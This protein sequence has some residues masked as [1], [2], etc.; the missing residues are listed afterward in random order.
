[1][2]G[3][4]RLIIAGIIGLILAVLIFLGFFIVKEKEENKKEGID[5]SKQ[6]KAAVVKAQEEVTKLVKSYVDGN[7]E[8]IKEYAEENSKVEFTIKELKGIFEIDTKKFNELK[9]G[10]SEDNTFIKLNNDY[11]DYVVVLGCSDFYID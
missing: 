9:Y 2:K 3:K 11:K 5:T 4:M 7:Y 1:M 6:D 10:C 8:K